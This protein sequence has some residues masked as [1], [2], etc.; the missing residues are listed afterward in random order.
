MSIRDLVPK[1]GKDRV[2]VKK[3]ENDIFSFQREINRLFDEF[4]G[5]FGITPFRGEE[6][7]LE[8]F[9]PSV[10]VSEN[11]KDV[12]VSAELPGMD[13]KDVTV[14]LDDDVLVLKGEKKME[15]DKKGKGWHRI[16]HRYGSF[17][18]AIQ[19]P[20]NVDASKAKAGFKKGVLT[21]TLP[22]LPEEEGKRKVINIASE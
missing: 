5:D 6:S 17:H 15:K 10:N 7:G 22:K 9:M 20:A 1:F 2:Q 12:V 19:L 3:R 18:R 11:E 14:E 4:F 13:E 21:V 8:T 16:E